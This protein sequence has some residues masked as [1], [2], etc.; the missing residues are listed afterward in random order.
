MIWRNRGAIA[1]AG[2]VTV[3]TAMGAWAGQRTDE[4]IANAFAIIVVLVF[5]MFMLVGLYSLAKL[6]GI[7]GAVRSAAIALAEA[8]VLIVL[9][10]RASGKD[11]YTDTSWRELNGSDLPMVIGGDSHELEQ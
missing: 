6:V 2:I 7:G 3:L 1:K 9:L 4:R 11:K 8:T 5:V 10:W